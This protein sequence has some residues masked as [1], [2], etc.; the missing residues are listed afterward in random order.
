[1]IIKGCRDEPMK[2]MYL[3]EPNYP[4]CGV[5]LK[6]TNLKHSTD[7]VSSTFLPLFSIATPLGKTILAENHV[8]PNK[9][10]NPQL[11]SVNLFFVF[12]T[13]FCIF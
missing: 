9:L 13:E 2:Q 11:F 3:E 12:F 1:M 7:P 4:H 10:T 6:E 5:F 8:L